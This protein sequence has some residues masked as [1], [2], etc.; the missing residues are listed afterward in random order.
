MERLRSH[1]RF[2]IDALLAGSHPTLE[3]LRNQLE[4]AVVTC[5]SHTGPGEYIDLEVAPGTT[6]VEPANI[7]LADVNL[8]VQGLPHGADALLY[9]TEGRISLLEL[10]TAGAE[11]PTDPVV[12][13]LSYYRETE[14]QPGSYS[15][16]P[17]TSRDAGTL[18]RALQGS[19]SNA[20]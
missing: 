7:V 17:Q 10:V 20:A 6:E 13:G 9:V 2:A 19:G 3:A 1:E 4:S 15:M 8:D 14:V 16:Q 11:W 18:A 5:R 12:V